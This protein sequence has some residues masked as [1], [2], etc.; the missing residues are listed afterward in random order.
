M[1][2]LRLVFLGLSITSSWG[3]GHATTYRSL[4]RHLAARGHDILFLERDVPWYA[5]NRDLPQP[6]YCNVCLYST[7]DECKARFATDV[8]DADAVIAGSYVPDG[9]QLATWVTNTARGVK[10]FYDIDTPVTLARLQRGEYEY[11]SPALIPCFDLYLSFTA[12]HTLRLI[13]D[14][15]GARRARALYC[16]V[17]VEVYRPEPREPEYDLGYLGTY[18]EDRQPSLEA[19]LCQPAR[20]WPE[21]E[22]VIAGPMYPTTLPWPGNVKRVE[23]LAPP[24][25]RQF[26]NSQRFTLNV[27]RGDML[28]AGYSPSVRLFEAAAC[29]TPII[30]DWWPGLETIFKPGSE[31][32]IAN[33]TEECLQYLRRMREAER[34]KLG[35]RARERVLAS[36]TAAHRAAEFESHIQEALKTQASRFVSADLCL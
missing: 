15:F 12:G 5:D 13:E 6:P 28:R 7:T 9:V 31:I 3:N 4:I 19:L 29:G 23:H 26:Y 36:H 30:S 10:A 21:G 22:F 2:Q 18:S 1:P 27:T 35:Q 20:S 33:S 24:R 34:I 32:L 25:H 14:R 8:R 11:L 16:S 17:D